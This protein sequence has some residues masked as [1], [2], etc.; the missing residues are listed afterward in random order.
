MRRLLLSLIVLIGLGAGRADAGPN[1]IYAIGFATNNIYQVNPV[2]GTVTLVY[3]GYPITPAAQNSAALAQRRSDGMLFYIAGTAGNGAVY[4][5]NPATPATAPVLLGRT[6]TGTPYMPRL[7][8]GSNDVLYAADNAGTQLY[9]IN[10]TTG[11]ATA[12][13][14]SL[15]STPTG[16]GDMALNP[17]DGRLYLTGGTTVYAVSASGGPLTAIGTIT[18]MTGTVVGT[19]FSTTGQFLVASNTNPARLYTVNFA[20]MAATPFS[21]TMTT[22]MGDLASSPL[23]DISLTKSNGSATTVAGTNTVYTIVAANSGPSGT[24]RVPVVD[25]APAGLTFGTWSC[26]ATGGGVCAAATGSGNLNTFADLPGGGTATYTVN[27][28]L[29]ASASGSITNTATAGDLSGVA[30]LTPLNNTAVDTDTVL[31]QADLSITKTDGVGSVNALGTTSYTVVLSNAGPSTGDGARVRDLAAAGLNK[32]TLSC[33]AAGGAV[34][35]ATL[36]IAALEGS[37]LVVPTLP[38]GGSVTL[39]IGA[40][41]TATSGSVVNTATAA[42]AAG[43]TDPTPTNDSASDTDSVT[44]IADVS[45]TKSDGVTSVNASATTTYTVTVSNAGPSAAD[46]TTVV[47]AAASGLSKTSVTCTAA[48]GAVCPGTLTVA[49]LE[50]SGLSVPTLPSG[51]SVT[52]SVT[53]TVTATSGAVVNGAS[54]TVPSGTV[55]PVANNDASDTDTVVPV[56]NLGVAKTDGVT[57]VNAGAAITYTVT[58]DNAGP[59]AAGGAIV[60][61]LIATGLAKTSVSCVPAGG[62]VCPGTLTVAALEGTGLTIPTLPSGGSVTL[63]IAATVTATS[64]SV[65]NTASVTAPSGTTDP[66]TGNDTSSDSDVV[67]PVADLTMSKTDGVAAVSAGGTT[68]YTIVVANAG[69][70]DAGGAVVTDPMVAGLSK[71]TLTCVAA[72]GAVCPATLTV[73]ALEGAG[74]TIPTLPSGASITL[75][76]AASVTATSG[77]VANTAN[78]TPPF[79]TVDPVAPNN[80]ATDTDTVTAVAD[81]GITKTDGVTA[82][83]AGGTTTYSIVVSNAG[84]SAAAGAIVTDPAAAGLTKTNVTCTASGGA[85]CPATVSVAALEGAGLVVPALPSGASLTFTMQATVTAIGGSVAN[86]AVVAVPSGVSDPV[87]G[88]NTSTDTNT[89]SPVADLSITKSDGVAT[90]DAGGATTFTIVAS[91]AGPSPAD[92][93]VVVDPG[94]AGFMLTSVSCSASGGATC[95]SAMSVASLQSTGLVVPTLPPGGSITLGVAATITATGGSLSNIATVTAPVGV[96]D[97]AV[98]NN[99]ATDTN[100]VRP[101]AN[102]SIN[103]SN[104]ASGVAA[105]ATTTYTIVAANAGPSPADGAVIVDPAAA[106]LSKIA[107]SCAATGGAVCPATLTIAALEGAGLVTGALPSGGS[108]TLTV[109]ATVTA[110]SGSVLNSATVTPPTGVTDPALGNNTASDLDS[111]DPVADVSIVKT[112]G[113]AAVNAGGFTSYVITVANAGPSSADG[114]IVLDPAAAGLTKTSVSCAASG[115]ASCPAV[116][117]L[118]AL[119]GTGLVIPT[120]PGGGVVTL[121]LGA[122]VTATVGSVSNAATAAPPAGVSDPVPANNS[123]TD[124]DTVNPIADLSVTKTDGVAGVTVGGSTTYAVVV[125]NAGPSAA[126]GAVLVDPVTAGLTKTGVTCVAAGGAACPVTMTVAALEGAGLVAGALPSGGSLTFTV[127]ASV[128]A[129]TGSITNTATVAPPAG[130]TDPSAGNNAAA[131]TDAVTPIADLAVTKSNGASTVTA[132][133][134]T[135]YTVVVQNHGPSN[136]DGALVTDPAAAGLVKTSVGCTAVG[137]AVCPA[138][139]TVA[140][141][142]GPGLVI[143]ALPSGATITLTVAAT[144]TATG[145]SIVNTATVSSASGVTDPNAANNS[146][147][148]TDAV[149]AIAD[150]SVTKS[151][152]VSSVAAGSSTSYSIAVSNAGPSAADG[153]VVVDP[154]A[155]GLSK[156]GVSCSASGSASCPAVMT[157]AAL[158]GSGLTIATLPPGGSVVLTVLSAVTASAGAVVNSVTV[159]APSG[160]GDP[161]ATNNSATD[162]N[163]VTPVADLAITKSNGTSTTSA[164]G[165]TAYTVTIN[166]AGPSAADG[167]VVSDPAVAGVSKSGVSCVAAGGAVCPAASTIAGLEGAGLVVPALPPGGSVAFTIA[168]TITAVAGSVANTATVAAP[169]GVVDPSLTNNSATDTDTIGAVADLAVTKSNGAAGVSA[170]STTT[171]TITVSNAGP[172][173]SDGAIVTDAAVSGL[174][175]T[176]VSCVPAGG[177][178]CPATTTVAALETGL[179]VPA[180]PSGGS[181]TLTVAATVTATTGSVVNSVT[182]TPPSGAIDPAP[183]NNTATD[184]DPVTAIANLSVSKTD[185]APSAN[186]GS[187]VVYSIVVSNAGPSAADGAVLIDPAVAGLSKSAISCAAAAGA[188]CPAPATTAALEAGLSIASL[189]AGS[190]VTVTVTATVTATSGSVVNVASIAPPSGV[191]DPSTSDNSATDTNAIVPVADLVVTNTDGVTSLTPGGTTIYTV[192]VTNA[193]PSAAPGAGLTVAA[194]SGITFTGWTCVGTGGAV[195]PASGVGNVAATIDVPAGGSVTLTISAAVSGGAVSPIATTASATPP[196][197]VVD[198]NLANNSATDTDTVGVVADVSVTKTNGGATVVAGTSTTYTIAVSNAGPSSAD[199]AVLIDAAAAGLTKTAVGCVTSGGAA[200]PSGLTIA[201][202]ESGV[203]IPTLPAGGSIVVTVTAHVAATGGT[204]TNAAIVTAAAGTTD[205]VAGNNAATDVDTVVRQADLSVTKSNGVSAV[206]SGLATTYAV[207]VTNAGPSAADGARIVDAAVAGLTKTSV[208]CVTTS[209]GAACPSTLTVA[210]LESVGLVMPTLPVGASVTLSVAATVTATTGTVSNVVS[211]MPPAGVVDPAATNDV[212]TDADAIDVVADLGLTK[213]NG[214]A[215]LNTGA[216]TVYTIVVT[217][218]GPGPGDGALV[219][220]PVTAGLAKTSV[221]CSSTTGGAVCPAGV[222]VASL[223]AGLTMGAL[224]PGASVTFSVAADVTSAG[225]TVSNVATVNAAAGVSDP[226]AA[227]NTAIDSDTITQQA[228]LSVTKSDGVTAVVA[229]GSTTYTVVVTNA[230][231]SPASGATIVDPAVPGLSKNA[232]ACAAAGGAVCPAGLT[233]AML[234]AGAT[235]ATLPSGGQLTLSIGA[236]ASG[237]TGAVA[238]VVAVSTPSGVADP[239]PSNDTATD[240]N[241]VSLLT[242]LSVSITDGVTSLTPGGTTTYTVVVGNGG[243]SAATAAPLSVTAPSGLTFGAWTCVA[244]GGAVCPAASSGNISVA[245]DVPAAGTLTFTVPATIAMAASGSLPVTATV[246]P[247]AGTTDPAPGN[248]TATDTDTVI[249]A[250]PTADLAVT[251]TNGAGSVDAGGSTTYTIVVTNHGPDAA[252]GAIVLDAAATGLTKTALTCAAAGGAACPIGVSVAALETSGLTMPTLPSGGS[253]TLSVVASVTAVG[254]T[255]VNVVSVTPPAGVTDPAPANNSASDT[256]G[257]GAVADLSVTK[258]NGVTSLTTGGVATYV[259]VVSNAGPAAADGAIVSDPATAGLVKTGVTCA[260]SAGAA[261]PA[262]VTVAALETGGLVVPALPQG[263]SLTL[264]VT[265]S[266]TAPSGSVANTVTLTPPAGVSDPVAGNNSQTDTDTIVATVAQADVAVT[267]DN[268]T[269]TVTAGGVTTYTITVTNAGPSAVSGAT[270]TS[271][272]PAGLTFGSWSCVAAG[273]ASCPLSGTGNLAALVNLPVGA[274][275]T[276]AVSAA[277]APAAAGTIA[278]SAAVVLPAGLNDPNAANNTAIDTDSVTAAVVQADLAITKSNNTSTLGPGATTVYTIVVTNAGPGAVAGATVRDA[279]S[280]ALTLGAWTCVASAGASCPA[281]GNGA[282]NGLVTLPAGGT[283]TFA[284]NATVASSATGSVSNTAT[285]TLPAGISDPTP[286]NNSATDEDAIPSQ[287]IAV[288]KRSDEPQYVAPLTFEVPYTIRVVNAGSIPATNVQVTDSLA[289]AFAAGNPAITLRAVPTAAAINGASAAQCATNPAFNGTSVTTLLSGSATFAPGQGCE[290]VIRVRV[291]YPDA[292]AIPAGPQVNQAMAATYAT[293][294]STRLAQDESDSGREP[295]TTNAGEPGDTGGAD[296]PT[297]VTFVVPRLDITKAVTRVEQVDDTTFDVRY[298]LKVK[299]T[300][301]VP[302]RHVQVSDDLAAAFS[303]GS[304]SLTIVDGPSLEDGDG[305]L[306]L[307]TGASAFDGTTRTLL[308]TGDDVLPAG[309]SRALAFTVRVRFASVSA[310]PANRPLLNVAVATSAASPGAPPLTLDSSSDVTTTGAEPTPSDEAAPTVALLTPRARLSIVKVAATPIAEVGESVTY[311]IRVTNQGGPFLPTTTIEDR[312]PLGFSYIDGTARLTVGDAA[313]QRLGEPIRAGATLA[314]AVPAQPTIGE[315]MLT[316]RVRVSVGA[317]Q[318]DGVNR[319]VAVT[320][321]GVRSNESFARVIV[322]GGVFTDDACVI[323]RVFVDVSGNRLADADEPGIPGVRV[324]LEDGTSIVTDASGNYSACGLRPGTHAIKIDR[325]T[326]PAGAQLVVANNR[327]AGDPD[328]MFLDLKFGELR[329]ADFVA[330]VFDASAVDEVLMQVESR[331]ARSE[332]GVLPPEWAG[333]INGSLAA[334]RGTSA[335]LIAP[336]ATSGT[337][338]AAI[339]SQPQL[340]DNVTGNLPASIE[341]LPPASGGA[342]VGRVELRVDPAPAS[343]DGAVRVNVALYDADGR[344]VRGPARVRVELSGGTM[345]GVDAPGAM[346][347]PATQSV[348]MRVPDTG[349]LIDVADGRGVIE[350]YAADRAHDVHLRATS[351]AASASGTLSFPTPARPV[352]AVGVLEGLIALTRVRGD[353]LTPAR[354]GDVFDREL[355]E[356]SRTLGDDALVGARGA[357]YLRGTVK[358]DYLMTLAYDSERQDRGVLF[359]DIQPDA[360]YPVYGD[361]SVKTFDAQTSGKFYLRVERGRSYLLYGDMLTASPIG[362]ARNLGTYS[363]SLTG[364]QHRLETRRAVVNLFASRDTLRQVIDEVGGRGI[365]GPYSVSN[366]NG[367]SGTEKIEI[368]TR[369]RNQP[370]LVLSAVPL[371]RF[372]DYEFEPFSGRVLFRKPVPSMDERL[373]P[374]SVR[375]TY[376]V[377]GG[378]ERHWVEG[379]DGQVGVGRFVTVGGSFAQDHNPLAPFALSSVNATVAFGASTTLV[380]EGA[381]TTSTVNTGSLNRA[382]S[383]NLA[384]LAGEVRGDAMRAEL[385]HESERLRARAYIGNADPAFN[386]PSASWYGGR[387]EAGGRASWQLNP[388]LLLRGEALRSRD[389]LTGGERRGGLLALESRFRRLTVEA[390]VRRIHETASP[391][392]ASSF[393]LLQPFSPVTASGF[394][395][396]AAGGAIDPATGLPI[397]TT[398]SS[399]LLTAGAG[400]G[401]FG[402]RA[403][404]ATTARA[405]VGVTLSERV[406]AYGEAEQD[407]TDA[408]K[409]MAAAGGE[410][411]FSDRGRF[412]GRHEFIS[413]LDGIYALSDTPRTQRT[414]FGLSTGYLKGGDAFSEYRM[415]DGLSGRETQA[416]IGL[417]HAWTVADGVRVS[418]GV[419]RLN[420]LRRTAPSATAASFGLEHTRSRD[421]KATG[422]LEWRR[423]GTSNNWLSTLGAARRVSRDWTLLAKNYY[424]LT[425]PASAPDQVQNRLW[426]GTAYRDHATNRV[427]LLSRYELRLE[428]L[429][430]AGLD[431]VSTDRTVHVVST[432]ADYHPAPAWALFGQYAGKWV[433]EQFDGAPT[434]D[435][436][437]LAATRATRDLTPRLDLGVMGSVMWSAADSRIRTALGGELGVLLRENMWLSFGYNLTGFHDRDFHDV[438][439]DGYTT[440]GAYVRLRVKFDET[441]FGGGADN[442]AR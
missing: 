271:V 132:A 172:S 223:E 83:S 382:T 105:A 427:N 66:I 93:T 154:A 120:L 151:D 331:R 88:N 147:I 43:T 75:T 65:V 304:P 166:N 197:G 366:P 351:G 288:A 138:S 247:A 407:V 61:D 157:V 18:G 174:T 144:V 293:P 80:T 307:A 156:T 39:T 282:L 195:C 229:G 278:T 403:V 305:H 291:A 290:L 136:A 280:S 126:G 224:P 190:S 294:G 325:T 263:G 137:G 202:L 285:V 402:G 440:R 333:G 265:A 21:G 255:V 287:R 76:V 432:H 95:P 116:A 110:S 442:K 254:G 38:V 330:Q 131:D 56:A 302:A 249:A 203:A 380:V 408:D 109:T 183:A 150:L 63:T 208:T 121:T 262:A 51:G 415:N 234:E 180:L 79:G 155:A 423:E 367:V 44:P 98:A 354:P 215:S 160:V 232:V 159:V 7:V 312:L 212:A 275:V 50:G 279:G 313:G 386:N 15:G 381:Q 339:A 140:A 84:P 227:N 283:A 303:L 317:P 414:V 104:G 133:G 436:A 119:E 323:G 268:G 115:G 213:T 297:P 376:E 73:A 196:S 284:V 437:H 11:A 228:N 419:E 26:T 1:D 295:T 230:G 344:L 396:R 221:V 135:T 360:F 125:S 237:A 260:A 123:A 266:V 25:A 296:D 405:R 431:A 404:E 373:N 5:W 62:A 34:C 244:T 319:A 399:P 193:G 420:T 86:T 393:G 301:S 48:G 352:M 67:T 40:A 327:Q 13:G 439:R 149:Q 345:A 371:T 78:V 326:M 162:T 199:G 31:R 54:A 90:V 375:I 36:T 321:G 248:N 429:P 235:I 374:V 72:G 134:T 417:K 103:K 357:M 92:G 388:S 55:D 85:V 171:Y 186:A 411:R 246:T 243:P 336:A 342:P 398:G 391:A 68:S 47:D 370:A 353:A 426:F 49:A 225:G 231:P 124:V 394:G 69:P 273:G 340:F 400:V 298:V 74:L 377:D 337:A 106:G 33:A 289:E 222:S 117:S 57:S 164:G 201:Q 320:D 435:H 194:P 274:S 258:S 397:V 316:Y 3:A 363:R 96:T 2:T 299:N 441:S 418:T 211:V 257:V 430:L 179:V 242:D 361:A 250:T 362:E 187:S 114:T 372:V 218:A 46:G 369:D 219:T 182:V 42:T 315:A 306:T 309:Q 81:L 240:T 77:T 358:G 173:A 101:I 111:V 409:R 143:P 349:T 318:G 364:A 169:A 145:G 272:A 165:A 220:D 158:E 286:A 378:G 401:P 238:N 20:T 335:G 176:G 100:T 53:A 216:A 122:T 189:P 97:P 9:S 22:G 60:R 236:T 379:A 389:G 142:E 328:S 413:S 412:Y 181:L 17:A 91:N 32:T 385:R 24:I 94:A 177:A 14:A 424:Q 217:N 161:N 428:R 82:V 421:L 438:L 52:L 406:S 139:S 281:N 12:I 348:E 200:C 239:D 269:T 259:I 314:F 277:V 322:R 99:S 395:F 209:G 341:P 214:V 267:I 118:A 256:D 387:A 233:V 346:G 29:A 334:V 276:F 245:V 130:V 329:R 178:I 270:M 264:T 41:V 324:V 146:A 167:A 10:T 261:C 422:R 311:A 365:S 107:V 392:Q 338:G 129:T 383:A 113:V 384:A 19:A 153:A 350:I 108:V 355:T 23:A 251:K 102:L 59:S 356:F 152:G 170:G 310:I 141:L 128:T 188:V 175:K 16:G 241:T 37:G 292:A 300:A 45:I 58:V 35:P 8:F 332:R 168:A 210:D 4:R 390:G 27:A 30:D 64:G 71:T 410:L 308:L 192:V 185:G 184:T 198:P 343:A 6:G 89:V 87:V 28:A 253:V 207:V 347:E 416:A 204:V 112:D 206:T 148:D 368:I 226:S 434:R 70:S 359:R 163:T 252:H 425:Q 205:P 191:I 433:R 127:T